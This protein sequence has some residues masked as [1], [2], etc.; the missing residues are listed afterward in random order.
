MLNN[1]A[2]LDADAYRAIADYV[3]IARQKFPDDYEP[4][5][6][7]R[8]EEIL[9]IYVHMIMCIHLLLL[10]LDKKYIDSNEHDVWCK[11]LGIKNEG[12]MNE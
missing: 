10:N 3:E 2:R 1:W 12:D 4:V 9:E 11:K 8:L 7:E 5:D 6:D